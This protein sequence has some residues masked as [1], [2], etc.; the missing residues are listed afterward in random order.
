[1]GVDYVEVRTLDI[2]ML[3]P[4]GVNQNQLR[5]AEAALIYCLLAE[6]PPIDAAEQAE[7]DERDLVVAREGRKPGLTL[8]ESGKN[9]SM[10]DRGLALTERLLEVAAILDVDGEGYL[11]AVEAQR[12]ALRDSSLTPSAQLVANIRESGQGFLDFTLD[13]SKAHAEYFRSLSLSPDKLALFTRAAERSLARAQALERRPD[14]SFED[15]LAGYF[16]SILGAERA[17]L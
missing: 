17:I 12:T 1:M 13:L 15:Y 11:A 14:Q 7:I 4:V 5:F 3:D 8:P 6:S 9:V 16:G 2:N 10:R